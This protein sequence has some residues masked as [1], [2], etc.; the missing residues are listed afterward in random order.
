MFDRYQFGGGLALLF[1]LCA[2]TAAAAPQ[3]PHVTVRVAT[4]PQ[5]IAYPGH[6]LEKAVECYV[7]QWPVKANGQVIVGHATDALYLSDP[8][9]FN[10]IFVPY[11]LPAKFDGHAANF[12]CRGSVLVDGKDVSE[13]TYN[14]GYQHEK[15]TDGHTLDFLSIKGPQ[16]VTVTVDMTKLPGATHGPDC[17]PPGPGPSLD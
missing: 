1:A 3:G 4:C 7:V 2:V 17:P 5:Q 12:V 10:Q 11:S 8:N 6:K 13:R 16:Y 15:Q 14:G 9:L